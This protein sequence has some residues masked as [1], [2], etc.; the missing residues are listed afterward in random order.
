LYS[1][2]WLIH[3]RESER[4][5][6]KKDLRLKKELSYDEEGKSMSHLTETVSTELHP[7]PTPAEKLGLKE[8]TSLILKTIPAVQLIIHLGTHREPFTY[9]LLLLIDDSDKT[10]DHEISNKIEDNCRQLVSVF[11][12]VQKVKNATHAIKAGARF[13]NHALEKGEA[14]YRSDKLELPPT[15]KLTREEIAGRRNKNW[16]RWGEQGREFYKGAKQYQQDKNY[17]LAAFLLHQA[18]ESTLIA[19]IK[20]GLGYRTTTHSLS[21]M[22][23][24]TLLSTD[25]IKN[26][27]KL[28][29]EEGVQ[30]YNLL[31]SAYSYARYKEDFNPDEASINVL[32]G[33]V[34][35]LLRT[36]E[37]I[38]LKF[39]TADESE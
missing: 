34:D 21:R 9:Y 38:Y 35:T 4:P 1:A 29:T 26:L 3:Q 10:A 5:V 15:I 11:T 12:F 7:A 32:M 25:D 13:I 36:A 18:A 24:I 6:L 19:L 33:T 27:F 2:A 17:K 37:I 28:D 30:T 14:I 22:L 39:M 20:V 8:V 16:K 31:Q 23:K